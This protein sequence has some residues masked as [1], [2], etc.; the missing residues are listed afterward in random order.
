MRKSSH[1]S[2]RSMI[3]QPE[4]EGNTKGGRQAIILAIFFRKLHQIKKKNRLGVPLPLNQPML[5]ISLELNQYEKF[6]S[7]CHVADYDGRYTVPVLW[8][9]KQNRFV[10]NESSEIIR[11]LNSEFNEFCKTDEQRKLDLYPEHLRKD[12]D[13]LNDWIYP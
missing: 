4:R 13:A 12:I 3:S 5:L 1:F 6:V 2:E 10:S 9:K 11:M 8:D 7:C